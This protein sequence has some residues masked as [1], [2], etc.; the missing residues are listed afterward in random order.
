MLNIHLLP[1]QCA[2]S[3]FIK[4]VTGNRERFVMQKGVL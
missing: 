4:I 3:T 1:T 2:G